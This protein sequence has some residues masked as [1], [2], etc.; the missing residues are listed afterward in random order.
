MSLIV[1]ENQSSEDYELPEPK[2][3]AARCIAAIGLG[4]HPNTHP[5]AKPG[6]MKQEVMLIWELSEL[7]EDGRPFT[8]NWRGTLSLGKNANLTKLLVS[9]RNKDFTD[10]EKEGFDLMN[11]V[12]VSCLLTVKIKGKYANVGSL[13]PLPDAMAASLI[14]Q[15]NP[16]VK[17]TVDQFGKNEDFQHIWPWV[18]RILAES[19]EGKKFE[20]ANPDFFKEP[21]KEDQDPNNSVGTEPKKK[22]PAADD[23]ENPF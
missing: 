14:D 7:M 21:E 5:D 20:K 17:F 19:E 3:Y 23:L 12:G 1:S 22:E 16:T 18:K 10:A 11:V 15:V 8:V 4:T 13:A 9:W 2:G 6:Q